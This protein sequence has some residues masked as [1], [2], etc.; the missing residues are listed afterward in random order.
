MLK[1]AKRFVFISLMRFAKIV[2]NML[3]FVFVRLLLD[4]VII[5]IQHK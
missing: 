2:E 3:L 4:D 5:G 1:A